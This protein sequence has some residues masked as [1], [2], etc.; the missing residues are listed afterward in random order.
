MRPKRSTAAV[1]QR[2][3]AGLRGRRRRGRRSPRRQRR[4]SP[5]DGRRRLGVRALALH[6]AAEVVDDDAGAALRRA[7]GVRPPDP[8]PRTGDDGDA[9]AEPVLGHVSAAQAVTRRLEA[10]QPAEGAA[11]DRGPLVAGNTGELLLDQLAAAAER[12][13]CVRVVVAPHDRRQAGD[14]PARDRDR[15]VLERDVELALARTRS[16]SAGTATSR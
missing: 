15:I 1:D 8:A 7:A 4:R 16:A 11:E 2:L 13:L 10:E 3:G 6:R 9:P 14:V 5:G 12:A